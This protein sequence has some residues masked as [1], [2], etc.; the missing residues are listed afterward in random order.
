MIWPLHYFQYVS[1]HHNYFAFQDKSETNS[2]LVENNQISIFQSQTNISVANSQ[3]WI[4]YGRIQRWNGAETGIKKQANGIQSHQKQRQ[5]GA[6]KEVIE[7]R[8]QR[9]CSRACWQVIRV[10]R[11]H[12]SAVH[13]YPSS[14]NIKLCGYAYSIG[15]RNRKIPCTIKRRR[16]FEML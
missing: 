8:Y 7:A 4:S 1:V 9:E 15:R 2:K 11:L 13:W 6:E 16:N 10:L 5:K 3:D 12:F 14:Q